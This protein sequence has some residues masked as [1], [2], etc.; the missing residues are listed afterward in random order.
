MSASVMC[1]CKR[2]VHRSF[3]QQHASSENNCWF[4]AA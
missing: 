4:E 3:V 1:I 2:L